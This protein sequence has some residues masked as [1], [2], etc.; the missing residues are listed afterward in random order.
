[1]PLALSPLRATLVLAVCGSTTLLVGQ[2]DQIISPS[3]RPDSVE[4]LAPQGWFRV[5]GWS[6][7]WSVGGFQA[8]GGRL[9]FLLRTGPVETPARSAVIVTDHTGVLL[10]RL[11]FPGGRVEQFAA[12][13]S[14]RVLA[15]LR[16]VQTDREVASLWDAS[17]T[18]QS[19]FE[20]SG[21]LGFHTGRPV[22]IHG[23]T[24]T[25]LDGPDRSQ[26][27]ALPLPDDGPY[28]PL[29]LVFARISESQTAVV[30]KLSGYMALVDGSAVRSVRLSAPEI[31][32]FRNDRRPEE[33]TFSSVATDGSRHI[34][35]VVSRFKRSDGGPI[36]LEFD[37]SGELRAKYRLAPIVLG[38]LQS[39]SNPNGY[40]VSGTTVAAAGELLTL[41]GGSR[42]VVVRYPLPARN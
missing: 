26:G 17:G 1:M 41:V 5:P 36:V 16:A 8:A 24:L 23:T 7:T 31:E 21:L 2:R 10:R 22:A 34:Y 27:V 13:D 15:R 4:V 18:L 25:F 32:S 39:K 3:E 14:G 28:W 38:E 20:E 19:T 11:D 9:F 42:G 12:D 33:L 30:S 35:G 37:S 29:S 40:G 6:P